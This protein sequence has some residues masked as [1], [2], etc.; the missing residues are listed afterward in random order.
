MSRSTKTPKG[1]QV[2]GSISFKNSLKEAWRIHVASS[3]FKMAV[4]FSYEKYTCSVE[5]SSRTLSVW[6]EQTVQTKMRNFREIQAS[7]NGKTA[8]YPTRREP[9]IMD[10]ESTTC[11]LEVPHGDA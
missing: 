2:P 9:N 5:N 10:I 8:R 11:G 4:K 7:L 3:I 6:C 1:I